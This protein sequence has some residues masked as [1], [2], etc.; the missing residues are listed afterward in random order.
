MEQLKH[1]TRIKLGLGFKSAIKESQSEHSCHLIQTKD[2]SLDGQIELN[3]LTRVEPESAT[4]SHILQVNDIVLRLRGPVFSSAI[5][6][7]ALE[8]QVV[9]TNQ[10]AVIR[11]DVTKV[12][13]YYLHWYL[14]SS[15]GQ[16]YFRGVGEG[17][18]INKISAKIVTDLPLNLPSMEEQLAIA[19]IHK[20]WSSQRQ[21]Y[22]KL[23]KNGN[24]L[25]NELCSSVQSK[26][27]QTE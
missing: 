16:R 5:L 2:I 24:Q 27:G 6:D 10:V 19:N 25:F 4:D 20:N 12:L 21:V 22:Q 23:I 9:A 8:K 11:C 17:T 1:V 18:N 26:S 15:E 13:P 14:N 3:S 7:G